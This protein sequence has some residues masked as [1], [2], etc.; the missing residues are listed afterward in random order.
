MSSLWFAL[1]RRGVSR[2]FSLV[3]LLVV[4]T[5]I[6]ILISL[7]LPAVQAAREAARRMQCNNNLKQWGLAMNLYENANTMFP[8]GVINP[9][10][11]CSGCS[12]TDGST[13]ANGAYRRQTFVVALW[14][15]VDQQALYDLYDFDYSFYAT[16]NTKALQTLVPMYFCPSDRRGRHRG[17]RSNGNYELNWGYADY[18]QKL[19]SDRKPGPFNPNNRQTSAAE[20]SNGLSNTMFLGEVIQVPSDLNV[21]DCRGDFFNND[22]GCSQF[23]TMYTPNSGID[24]FIYCGGFPANDPGP[25]LAVFSPVYMSARSR[26]PGG[27]SVVFGDGTVRFVGN[28]IDMTTWRA[29]SSMTPGLPIGALP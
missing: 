13:G 19:P 22:T 25:C 21:A 29:I 20:I 11:G 10:N 24:T 8:Y 6:G 16:A 18:T 5:L 12:T 2:A 28:S 17:N 15:Y 27:V 26:H 1:P 14:P 9:A 4:V 23:M 3:E 7:L